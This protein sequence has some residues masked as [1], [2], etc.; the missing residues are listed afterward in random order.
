MTLSYTIRQATAQDAAL[1]AQHRKLMFADEGSFS[2]ADQVQ[3]EER[4]AA[5]VLPKLVSGDYQG[6]FAEIESGE[7]IGGVGL[8]LREWPPILNND[9]GRQGYIENVYTAPMY[10]RQ[11]VAR[12]LMIAL[13]DWVRTTKAV[14]EIELHPTDK[15]RAL[16]SSLG[17]E[18]YQAAMTQWFGPRN[19]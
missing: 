12:Q 15:A 19:E 17:F 10:R 9:T 4:Y 11:G 18:S 13:L 6:W 2:K 5:W 3:M 14:Y 1:I 16:Y 8:W 7:V